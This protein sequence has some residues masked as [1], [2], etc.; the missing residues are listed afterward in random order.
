M[1]E[2]DPGN[3]DAHNMRRIA[4][5]GRW[6]CAPDPTDQDP[7]Q[8][9][10]TVDCCAWIVDRGRYC[11]QCD[12][13]DLQ[14]TK[15]DVLLHRA[16]RPDNERGSQFGALRSTVRRLFRETVNN[17]TPLG[18]KCPKGRRIRMRNPY[19]FASSNNRALSTKQM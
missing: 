7:G 2:V 4:Q 11:L 10:D 16:H 5:K 1:I 8:L 19:A 15:F 12:I 6:R 17:G 3:D 13:D 9:I 14:H 18:T